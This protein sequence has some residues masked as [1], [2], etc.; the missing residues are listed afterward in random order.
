MSDDA[1]KI[2]ENIEKSFGKGAITVAGDQAPGAKVALCS[3]GFEQLDDAIGVGGYPRGRVVELFGPEQSGK[4]TLC[5][6]AIAAVQKRGW[7]A[8]FIDAEH[9]FEPERAARLGVDLARLLVSQPDTGE[10]GLE[11]V[12]A[13]ARSGALNLIVVDSVAALV[14]KAEIEGYTDGGALQGRMMSQALRKLTAVAHRTGTTILFVN[15]LRQKV[16]V[17]FGHETAAGGNALKFY[18]SV[19]MD[20]RRGDDGLTRVRVVKNKCAA[21]F[22]EAHV[23]LS[24]ARKVTPPPPSDPP[25]SQPEARLTALCDYEDCDRH[26][27]W[28]CPDGSKRCT[29]HAAVT[30]LL[31]LGSEE[32][33][34]AYADAHPRLLDAFTRET[35]QRSVTAKDERI[36]ELEAE[37]HQQHRDLVRAARDRE[38]RDERIAEL[39]AELHQHHDDRPNAC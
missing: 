31:D 8:A 29:Y 16:G 7:L 5:L 1:T 26:W 19:R 33:T 35:L 22:R 38:A 36:A 39:E 10:Q 15:H 32:A 20:V 9:E 3:T 25:P 24:G 4:T 23:D 2:R 30:A 11:I 37:L 13:L 28:T 17:V 12:E 21:P 14:P 6:H 27:N 34:L 18:A